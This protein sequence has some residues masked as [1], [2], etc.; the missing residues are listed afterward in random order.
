MQTVFN[1][2]DMHLLYGGRNLTELLLDAI[3]VSGFLEKPAGLFL[4]IVETKTS[5]GEME[6]KG[7]EKDER[8]PH[9]SKKTRRYFYII[10]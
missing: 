8:I 10:Y 6:E 1:F 5:L 7:K 9:S 4:S 2:S 3:S